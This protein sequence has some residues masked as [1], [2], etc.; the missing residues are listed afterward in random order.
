MVT[1]ALGRLRT[2]LLLGGT[3]EIGLAI[4]SAM[5]GRGLNTVVLA[6][7]RP[8]A[9]EA[10]AVPLRSAGLRV[11][12]HAFDAD[13]VDEHEALIADV[14]ARYGDLD[15]TIVAFGVLGDQMQGENDP[16]AAVAVARTNFVGGI[17][18]LTVLGRRLREQGHGKIIVLS[19]VAGEHVRRSNYI[20]GASKAGLDGFAL[21]L[22]EALMGT[23]ASVL[24]VRPGFVRTR[25]TTGLAIPPLST[26]PA[27]V[28]D[29]VLQGLRRNASIIWV[30]ASLRGVISVLRHLPRNVVRRIPV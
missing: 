8:A 27:Q 22:G 5:A 20:Y 17:S 30:P 16:H 19:S 13:L 12:A 24:V 6:G 25:M 23:G 18:V 29:A 4:V 11:A 1:D 26:T 15:A 2:V 21:A 14:V 3:S 10:A 9:L 28:A 7:R